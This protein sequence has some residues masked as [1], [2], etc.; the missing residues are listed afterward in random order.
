MILL[1]PAFWLVGVIAR[2]RFYLDFGMLFTLV[3]TPI[4]A[5]YM[6][7]RNSVKRKMTDVE[8][9]ITSRRVSIRVGET[10][11]V[12][13]VADIRS[14]TVSATGKRDGEEIGT[15][16]LTVGGDRPAIIMDNM[17][18]PRKAAALIRKLQ[19][20]ASD[21]DEPRIRFRDDI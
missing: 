6:L 15:M 17:P 2:E 8:F 10:E 7:Y 13:R 18:E 5:L 14:V 21:G 12:V 20:Q 4:P 1:G 11:T 16:I 19:D 9:A 3:L